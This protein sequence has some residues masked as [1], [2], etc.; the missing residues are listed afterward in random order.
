MIQR[1]KTGGIDLVKRVFKLYFNY[2]K[3][4]VWLNEMARQGWMMKSFF[5]GLFQ[6]VPGTPGEYIYRL[7]MLPHLVRNPK[8]EQYV[9][10]LQDMDIEIISSWFRWVICRRK[11][12]DGS[13]TIYSDIDSRIAHYTRISRFLFPLG[14]VE[15][16]VAGFEGYSLYIS[17][18][19]YSSEN[20][21]LST[22]FVLLFAL[23]FAFLILGTAWRARKK[24]LLLVKEKQ[25]M[26]SLE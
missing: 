13:F 10:F 3:E 9:H 5:L 19:A 15:L 8:N 12:S 25:I 21:V 26:E 7:E 11:A 18:S 23:C 16:I 22:V 17:L 14:L 24:R 1:L 2:E 6:F 4:E 20:S